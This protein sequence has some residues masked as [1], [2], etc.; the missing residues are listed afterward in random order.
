[1]PAIDEPF[2]GEADPPTPATP[3]EIPPAPG[4]PSPTPGPIEF[5]PPDEPSAPPEPPPEFPPDQT[6]PTSDS[7]DSAD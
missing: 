3:V 7:G 4:A 5:P 1:M 6:G 2:R